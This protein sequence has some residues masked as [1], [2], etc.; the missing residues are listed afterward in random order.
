MN[1][2]IPLSYPLQS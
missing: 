1:Q 2:E